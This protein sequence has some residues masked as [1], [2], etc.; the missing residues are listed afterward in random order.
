[1]SQLSLAIPT[2]F[3]SRLINFISKDINMVFL[4]YKADVYSGGKTKYTLNSL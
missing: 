3:G 1:M 4:I 2:R